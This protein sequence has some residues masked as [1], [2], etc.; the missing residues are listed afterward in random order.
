MQAI[1]T[2]VLVR[3]LTGDDARPAAIAESFVE[4]AGGGWVSLLVLAETVWMLD[5]VYGRTRAQLI[6]V[7]DFG[8]GLKL[9]HLWRSGGSTGGCGGR[10]RV[11]ATH[12]RRAPIRLWDQNS[13][14]RRRS[15]ASG[16]RIFRWVGAPGTPGIQSRS[17]DA[18]QQ[19]PLLWPYL[20][21]GQRR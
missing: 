19:S 9:I 17:R 10:L 1:D 13:N 2:N 16:G 6:A 21:P 15:I 4:R 12:S 5:F 11:R 20:E 18:L 7:L 8:A 3:L 14:R